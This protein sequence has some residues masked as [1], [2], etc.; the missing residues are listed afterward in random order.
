MARLRAVAWV[1]HVSSTRRCIPGAMLHSSTNFRTRRQ[2]GDFFMR[3]A[4]AAR[5]VGPGA[6][7]VGLWVNEYPDADFLVCGPG[8]FEETIS[9]CLVA[10]G[11]AF[12]PREG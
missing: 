3:F 12:V 4:S 2:P 11:V 9:D 5:R 10:A 7:E 6:N 1:N 8:A